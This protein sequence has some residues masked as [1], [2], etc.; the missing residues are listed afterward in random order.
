M[1][2]SRTVSFCAE[3]RLDGFHRY[4]RCVPSDPDPSCVSQVSQVHSRREDLAVPGPLL[5]S[6]HSPT[7]LHSRDGSCV[8]VPPSARSSDASVTRRLADSCVVSGG[9]L[10]G[11]GSGSQP[12]SGAGNCSQ[13]GEVDP[14]SIT[15]SRQI[16]YL[17]IRIDSQTFR[18]SATPSRIEKVFS[19]AEEFLS[20]K[21]QSAK[22]WRVLLGHLAS[23]SRL[24]PNG[25]LRMRAFTIGSKSRLGFSGRGGPGSLGSS[26]LR[27]SSVV[28]H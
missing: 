1:E 23:L 26:F 8:G 14:Y 3:E 19:I 4:E 10:L 21:V 28:V 15:P 5:W 9:S 12:L 22:F 11:K 17:G 20:S 24:V 18:A 25:Q 13:P 7:G 2:T 16:T 6:V 27:R